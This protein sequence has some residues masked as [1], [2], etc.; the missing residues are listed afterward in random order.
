[1]TPEPAGSSVTVCRVT[2]D[3]LVV[4]PVPSNRAVMSCWPTVRSDVHKIARPAVKGT[5]PSSVEPSKKVTL[6]VGVGPDPRTVAVNSTASPSRDLRDD[7]STVV[8]VVPPLVSPPLDPPPGVGL[9]VGVVVPP[10]PPGT[11]VV[12]TLPTVV[13]EVAP[14][15]GVVAPKVVVV[16]EKQAPLARVVVV[17]AQV[18]V[19]EMVAVQVSVLAPVVPDSLHWSITAAGDE[20]VAAPVVA[21][22]VTVPVAPDWLHCPI[23][24]WPPVAFGPAGVAVQVAVGAPRRGLH[25]SIV[26]RAT[27]LAGAPVM[28]LVIV[29][30]HVTVAAPSL[31]ERLHW[32]ISV[33]GEVDVVELVTPLTVVTMT[34]AVVEVPSAL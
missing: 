22:Q 10:E 21:V 34:E 13:G 32:L 15:V 31:P 18:K 26:E 25:W 33:M 7:E 24:W 11:L 14:V 23:A 2:G 6:P 19:F 17:P 8:S 20:F 12:G 4:P 1:M 5:V 3:V 27:A 16:A 29:E 28:L 30:V 9:D